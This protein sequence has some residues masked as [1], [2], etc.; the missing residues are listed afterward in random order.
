MIKITLNNHK[1]LENLHL[2]GIEKKIKLKL[3]EY[4]KKASPNLLQFL[5]YLENNLKTILCGNKSDL[6]KI[7][8]EVEKNYYIAPSKLSKIITNREKHIDKSILSTYLQDYAKQHKIIKF[9][10]S[11]AFTKVKH[12]EE[13][14]KN[15]KSKWYGWKK[16]LEDIFDYEKFTKEKLTWSAYDLVSAID[17]SVCPY[18]NRNYITT[19]ISQ[20]KR[21]RAVLDH[22]FAKSL[23]SYLSLSLSNLIPSCYVCNSSFKGDKD[24][25]K[26][27]AVYPYEEDFLNAAIFKTDF[28]DKIPYNY[29]YLLGI[30]KEFKI[31]FDI[32]T[33]DKKL[34]EKI[35]NSIETFNLVDIY[36]THRDVVSDLIRNAVVNNKTRIDEIYKS[37]GDIFKS[38]DEV[39][40]S[41][42]LNYLDDQNVGKRTLAKLTQD[43][44]R[45]IGE[46]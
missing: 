10:P 20:D 27:D 37:Y 2:S 4:K 34:E 29:R 1:E 45:E 43:I 24:F 8:G 18:C 12:F 38:K 7:I 40:Q 28:D 46:L 33:L 15:L 26:N 16:I 22:Y 14:V 17:I 41:I 6:E 19:L 21:T 3:K 23:Y 5:I 32:I 44:L 9:L 36:N 25:Y 39:M 35:K 42:Y 30:S 11:K 13:E 31:N